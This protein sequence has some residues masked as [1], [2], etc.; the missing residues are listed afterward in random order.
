LLYAL[1][2]DV[3]G[4]MHSAG[5]FLDAIDFD[6]GSGAVS[7]TSHGMDGFE[8]TRDASGQ[9]FVRGKCDGTRICSG[10]IGSV[11]G[12]AA[13][14]SQLVDNRWRCTPLASSATNVIW[15]R[16]TRSLLLR[17]AARGVALC[18]E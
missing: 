7:R 8:V 14:E 10:T 6:L 5:T 17:P 15:N 9:I 2:T 11:T 3:A 13:F 1:T 4:K 12:I 18:P 16:G